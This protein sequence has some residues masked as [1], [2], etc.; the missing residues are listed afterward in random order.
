MRDSNNRTI[1]TAVAIF[2]VKLRLALS[3]KVLTTLF[4]ISYVRYT[5]KIVHSVRDALLKD[6]VPK[7]MGPGHITRQKIIVSLLT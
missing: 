4:N 1:R 6:F 7:F 2:F 3:N 5:G